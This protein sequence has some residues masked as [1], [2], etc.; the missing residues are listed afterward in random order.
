MILRIRFILLHNTHV[1]V[2]LGLEIF[3]VGWV[4]V[5]VDRDH[6]GHCGVILDKYGKIINNDD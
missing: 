6:F 5:I 3:S 4:R 2:D 1:D